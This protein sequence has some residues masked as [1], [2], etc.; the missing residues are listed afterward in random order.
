M[1]N[2]TV[3][4]LGALSSLINN[5]SSNRCAQLRM[6]T[7]LT[8]E[9]KA[10]IQMS[11]MHRRPKRILNSKQRRPMAKEHQRGGTYISNQVRMH[12]CH[13][14]S[15][16]STHI[17]WI[18]TWKILNEVQ[19]DCAQ[20]K[21]HWIND[22]KEIAVL[23]LK[24]EEDEIN[25]IIR[26][27]SKKRE[28]QPC[29][30]EESLGQPCNQEAPNFQAPWSGIIKL[31]KTTH[32]NLVLVKRDRQKGSQVSPTIPKFWFWLKR[33]ARRDLKLA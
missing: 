29:Q 4:H 21:S 11:Q 32:K 6:G 33:I 3:P 19:Q 31:E 17:F 9:W 16:H 23:T 24:R 26:K 25:P 5:E 30:E 15:K 27:I 7:T 22:S 10:N 8:F 20:R 18:V 2:Q 28:D 14:T 12:A 1:M 13:L